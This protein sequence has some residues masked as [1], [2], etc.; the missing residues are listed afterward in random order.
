[1]TP[2]FGLPSYTESLVAPPARTPWNTE[3]GAGGSSGGAAVAV[4]AGL[5]PFA[6]GSDGGGSVRIP[7]AATGL[8]GLKPS[9]GLVPAG[10]GIGSLAGLGL[11]GPIAR[12]G[13]DAPAA[14]RARDRAGR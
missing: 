2:E 8:V 12:T 13:A 7:A 3:L 11:A 14:P 4:A 10:S 1:N 6:P 5:L 9:R